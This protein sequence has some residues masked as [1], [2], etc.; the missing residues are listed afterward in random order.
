MF[1]R[2]GPNKAIRT[3]LTA[4]PAAAGTMPRDGRLP[5]MAEFRFD[6]PIMVRSNVAVTTFGEAAALVRSF[7]GARRPLV[8]QSVLRRLESARTLEERRAAADAFRGW[9]R[10]EGLLLGP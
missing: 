8:Q 9:A 6:P 3:V 2:Y 5:D 7:H 1:A 4:K 10:T